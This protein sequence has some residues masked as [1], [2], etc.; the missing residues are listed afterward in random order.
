MRY[1]IADIHGCCKTFHALIEKLQLKESDDLY[2]LG[3]Y[4]DRGP[5]SK[6]VLEGWS[7]F[8]GQGTGIYKW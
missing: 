6:G 7:G 4:I 5:D 3:D 1:A 8:L 2:L